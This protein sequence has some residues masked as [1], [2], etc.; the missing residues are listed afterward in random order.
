MAAAKEWPDLLK[1]GS[2]FQ[3][4]VAKNIQDARAAGLDENELPVIRYHAARMAALETES[5]RVP[6]LVKKL[7]EAEAKVKE[8]EL[9]SAPGGGVGAVQRQPSGQPASDEDEGEALRREAAENS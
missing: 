8:L 5:A 2:E 3:K 1:D 7:G 6:D 4:K 9:L